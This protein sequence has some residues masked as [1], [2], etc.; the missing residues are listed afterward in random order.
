M[1]NVASLGTPRLIHERKQLKRR[2]VICG[3]MAFAMQMGRISNSLAEQD[4]TAV[5]PDDVDLT[6]EFGDQETYMKFKRAVS[7]AHIAKVRDPKTIGIVVAN[8][9][10]HG[11]RSYIGPNTFAEIAI[12]FADR[13]RIFLLNG[14]PSTYADELS[15]WG[16]TDLKGNL[17]PLVGQYNQ[18]C[19]K[20][21]SQLNLPW[22]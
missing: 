20:D 8:F 17:Q 2:F 19:Q 9:E 11:V 16:V 18:L 14:I 13:K 15:A 12:A 3:S 22:S 5:P 4:V 7:R 21:R 6:A 1:G 10:K